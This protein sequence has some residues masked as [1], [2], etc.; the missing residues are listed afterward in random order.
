M[1]NAIVQS[2]KVK[3]TL[4]TFQ[5][6]GPARYKKCKTNIAIPREHGGSKEQ[7][8]LKVQMEGEP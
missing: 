1:H 7:E 3:L 8:K 6:Y 2:R 5:G 4:P